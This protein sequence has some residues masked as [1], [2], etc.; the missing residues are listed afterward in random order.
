M[1]IMVLFLD[2]YFL[3]LGT[4]VSHLQMGLLEILQDR[5]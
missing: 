5:I 2:I 1:V 3:S 4:W